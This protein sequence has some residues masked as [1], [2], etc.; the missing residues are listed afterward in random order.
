M[1]VLVLSALKSFL[2]SSHRIPHIEATIAYL[3]NL[4]SWLWSL[5]LIGIFLP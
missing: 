1:F 4:T 5:A 3:Y 2:A